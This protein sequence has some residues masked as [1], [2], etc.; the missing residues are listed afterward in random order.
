MVAAAIGVA[1]GES[2]SPL[3]TF[4]FVLALAALLAAQLNSPKLSGRMARGR[5]TEAQAEKTGLRDDHVQEGRI[6]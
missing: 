3:Q 1:L 5:P 6:R 2:L 4:G